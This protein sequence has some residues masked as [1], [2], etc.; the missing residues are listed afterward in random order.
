MNTIEKL[1]NAFNSL[2]EQID[3]TPKIAIVCGTGLGKLAELIDG[4]RAIAYEN[5]SCMPISTVDGHAGRFIFG[6]VRG[7]PVVIMQG[8]VHIYEGY[9]PSD[10]VLPIRLMKLMGAEIL[11]LSN[12]SGGI[13]YLEPGTLM[14][15]TD[16]ISQMVP[17]PLVGPNIGSLGVR[18]PD[19]SHIYDEHLCQLVRDTAKD[20]G[21]DLKEGIYMQFG[22]PQ[23][24]SPAEIRMAKLLGADA[25]GMSTCTEAIAAVH[26]GMKVIGVSCIAN[27]AAGLSDEPL[28]HNHVKE[29]MHNKV[30]NLAL[31]AANVIERIKKEQKW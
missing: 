28:D 19:M 24:E 25:V 26:M 27:P 15:I 3:F 7:V 21:I 17:S 2:K 22:G 4:F 13:S 31:L 6:Y 1:N 29:T 30:Q 9:T 23:Y 5:I 16:Q 10:S 14:L 11:M 18:F 20:I 8:R 12:A